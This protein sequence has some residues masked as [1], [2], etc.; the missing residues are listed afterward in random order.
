MPKRKNKTK[1]LK[2]EIL[3]FGDIPKMK[4]VYGR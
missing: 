1:K 4:K 3:G 2:E